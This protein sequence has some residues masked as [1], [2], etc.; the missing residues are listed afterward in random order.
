M[1]AQL[2]GGSS[3]RSRATKCALHLRELRLQGA[4][5]A[6]E[7]WWQLTVTVAGQSLLAGER[8]RW[9]QRLKVWA[10]PQTPEPV[11]SRPPF[12]PAAWLPGLP[13]GVRL[14]VP[15][16]PPLQQEV[17]RQRACVLLPGWQ[18]RVCWRAWDPAGRPPHMLLLR[19]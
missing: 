12:P 16:Q 3:N 1:E 7:D 14:Q 4:A 2:S 17:G 10:L 5:C 11:P 19:C 15:L 8:E 9:L 18:L 6:R 13:A